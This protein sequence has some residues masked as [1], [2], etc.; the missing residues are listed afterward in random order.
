[1]EGV[2]VGCVPAEVGSVAV[3]GGEVEAGEVEGGTGEGGSVEGGGGSVEGGTGEGGSVVGGEV[4][5]GGEVEAGAVVCDCALLAAGVPMEGRNI[6]VSMM[7]S[8]W[9]DLASLHP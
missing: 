4:E 9:I 7:L 1:M 3:V 2:L 5:E 8:H 6:K